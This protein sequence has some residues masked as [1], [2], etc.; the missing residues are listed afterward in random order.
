MDT[1]NIVLP[2]IS[3]DHLWVGIAFLALT[4]S[5]S[6]L[7]LRFHAWLATVSAIALGYCTLAEL[8]RFALQLFPGNGA[9]PIRSALFSLALLWPAIFLVAAAA[10]LLFSLQ[11]TRGRA[12]TIRSSGPL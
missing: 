11:V 5:A 2:L 8:V 6:L 9:S 3:I 4:V 7:A 10:V 1:P 12:L